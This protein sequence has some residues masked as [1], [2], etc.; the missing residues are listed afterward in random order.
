MSVLSTQG[1]DFGEV[2]KAHPERDQHLC[3]L[4]LDESV[5][6]EPLDLGEDFLQSVPSFQ[7]VQK[8]M[9][10]LMVALVAAFGRLEST[11]SSGV[12]HPVWRAVVRRLEEEERAT[13]FFHPVSFEWNKDVQKVR[14]AVREYSEQTHA[15]Y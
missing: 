13:N 6:T 15:N 1:L 8:P 3:S 4:L 9:R 10:S 12:I 14:E 5:S 11:A 2:L 7:A